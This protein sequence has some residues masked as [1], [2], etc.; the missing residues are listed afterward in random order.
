MKNVVPALS[1]TVVHES[2]KEWVPR[3][4]G[5]FLHELQNLERLFNR[6]DSLLVFRGHRKR[7]WL[8]DS[9][10][11]RSS[12][13][14]LF[15]LEDHSKFSRYLSGSLD[16]HRAL[17]NLFLLKFGI[18]VRPSAELTDLESSRG[19]D[20]WF[21]LMKRIQQHPDERQD[22]P[23]LIR[24]TNILDWTKSSDIALYFAND[25]RDADGAVYICDATATGKT[26]QIIPVGRILE[27]MDEDGNA[28]K[29]LGV[30]LMF[31][32]AHQILNQRA[33]NQQ[34][35]YFAQMDLRVDLETIWREQ[36]RMPGN[37][38]IVIKLVLPAGTESEAKEYLLGKGIT[39]EFL[40]P[41]S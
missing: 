19:I 36:E 33:K 24:G 31:H 26:R 37:E 5:D 15:G 29:A 27:K 28:G 21:E 20:P 14:K 9:T 3:S 12:K 8:L 25:N 34:A 39:S 6:E 32:P 23:F 7:E 30:P 1:S 10:F 35:I 2:E 11:V 13:S 41:N 18:L 40:Y 22:G 4:F 16:L 38:K 17:L